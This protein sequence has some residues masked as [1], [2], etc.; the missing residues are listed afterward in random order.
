MGYNSG[1]GMKAVFCRTTKHMVKLH[2]DLTHHLPFYKRV[3]PLFLP[4]E[5][6]DQ[7]EADTFS[8]ECRLALEGG[9]AAW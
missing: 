8:S 6:S 3:K 4:Q 1:I 9:R 2:N 7:R 5:S